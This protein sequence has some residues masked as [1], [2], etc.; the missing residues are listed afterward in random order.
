MFWRM[1]LHLSSVPKNKLVSS[2]AELPPAFILVSCLTNSSTLKMEVIYS[3]EMSVDFHQTTQCYIPVDSS[4]QVHLQFRLPCSATP[5]CYSQK[6]KLEITLILMALQISSWKLFHWEISLS[7]WPCLD[8]SK[9][10]N[11]FAEQTCVRLSFQLKNKY[12][13]KKY[14][15]CGVEFFLAETMRST[16]LQHYVVLYKST[17]VLEECTTSIFRAEIKPTTRPVRSRQQA[18]LWSLKQ[19]FH[20]KCLWT[21]TGLHNITKKI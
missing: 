7:T 19:C 17:R 6:S 10:G 8:L 15:N 11:H 18:Q 13:L 1:A 5:S 12:S 21:P 4:L 16:F 3:S 20:L 9:T 2:R 14:Q